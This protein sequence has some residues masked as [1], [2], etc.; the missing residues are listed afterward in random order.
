MQTLLLLMLRLTL[1]LLLWTCL[2]ALPFAQ[3]DEAVLP[4]GRRLPGELVLDAEG[5]L[6]FLSALPAGSLLVEQLQQVRFAAGEPKAVWTSA[7]YRMMLR[8]N[9]WLTGS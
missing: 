7:R 4:D 1:A 8:G 6:R 9:Q 2:P 5:R 3:A